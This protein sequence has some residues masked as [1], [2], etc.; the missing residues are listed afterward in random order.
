MSTH[1]SW[2]PLAVSGHTAPELLVSASF[3]Q[4]SYAV[5]VTD[6]ASVWAED[7]DRRDIFRRS[8]LE[9]TSI[10]PTEDAG[11]MAVFLGKLHAAFDP[12]SDEHHDTSLKLSA[13]MPDGLVIHVTCVLPGNLRALRWS[14]QLKRCPPSA[15]SG[16]L[17]IPLLRACQARDR[18]LQLL[19]ELLREKDGVLARM[20]DKLEAMGV[21]ME[22]IFAHLSGRR[23][24][25]TR[26]VAEERVPGL[27]PFNE[28]EFMA[29]QGSISGGREEE[30]Q[31]NA[32]ARLIRDVFCVSSGAQNRAVVVDVG[33][34]PSVG[35]WWA[36]LDANT[37]VSFSELAKDKAA[38][39]QTPPAAPIAAA[40]DDGFQAQA[41]PPRRMS[42]RIRGDVAQRHETRDHDDEST[43]GES[44]DDDGPSKIPDSHPPTTS[45]AARKR[46]GVEPRGI[47]KGEGSSLPSRLVA[48]PKAGVDIPM[49]DAGSETASD[50]EQP[51]APA[52][53]P[54]TALSPGPPKGGGGGLGRIGGRAKAATSTSKKPV[55]GLRSPSPPAGGGQGA[56]SPAPRRIGVIGKKPAAA[57]TTA[58]TALSEQDDEGSRGRRDRTL[59]LLSSGDE[60]Q[61]ERPPRETS[62]ERAARRRRERRELQAELDKKA[63][64][65][66]GKKKRKF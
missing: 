59:P 18:Q 60:T 14:M 36:E 20:T 7:M 58:K 39:A 37:S 15:I 65:G 1:R 43:E 21:G 61:G 29:K 22:S 9:E 34:P 49:N 19:A 2:Q 5:R 42:A 48:P 57:T 30:S 31:K 41:T 25:V 12:T 13:D 44:A 3:A 16:E 27:V 53:P 63:A 28:A 50:T 23:N 10:D 56:I 51:A 24:Q 26:A 64:A 47:A 6:L 35:D 38:E 4:A 17:V 11:Q 33:D 40:D 62:E 54:A 52:A 45:G 8:L 55:A 66:P 32:T 46:P